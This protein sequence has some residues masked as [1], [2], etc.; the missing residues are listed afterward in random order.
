[1][2]NRQAVVERQL[3]IFCTKKKNPQWI[4]TGKWEGK[5]RQE[6]YRF[7]FVLVVRRNMDEGGPGKSLRGRAWPTMPYLSITFKRTNKKIESRYHYVPGLGRGKK[8]GKSLQV[9]TGAAQVP[10]GRAGNLIKQM[11]CV[12]G[13]RSMWLPQMQ[14]IFTAGWAAA[15]CR[16]SSDQRS[17]YSFHQQQKPKNSG[18]EGVNTMENKLSSQ[19][20]LP[21][22]YPG[23]LRWF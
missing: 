8:E 16:G 13:D 17:V 14:C 2:L 6:H 1:M 3:V 23:K 12:W 19:G 5:N 10:W 9:N 18:R 4:I 20:T 15:L 11:Y 7:S 21:T 22:R